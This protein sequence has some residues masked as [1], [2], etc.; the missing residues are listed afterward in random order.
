MKAFAFAT[1]RP[2]AQKTLRRTRYGDAR[3]RQVLGHEL[4]KTP[5]ARL[6]WTLS[7]SVGARRNADGDPWVLM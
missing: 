4:G 6:S 7:L 1:R 3:G 5:L 2:R